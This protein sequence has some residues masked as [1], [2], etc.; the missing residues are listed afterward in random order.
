[1]FFHLLKETDFITS[2]NHTIFELI[3]IPQNVVKGNHL[4]DYCTSLL[5]HSLKNN[6]S[7]INEQVYRSSYYERNIMM[8]C[9]HSIIPK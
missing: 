2:H 1:M 9:R 4:M 5:L 3:S 8:A 7:Y 6:L